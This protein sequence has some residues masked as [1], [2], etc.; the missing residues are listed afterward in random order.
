MASAAA[1]AAQRPVRSMVYPIGT[2]LDL[3]LID[4]SGQ[5]DYFLVHPFQS[6]M[7][8]LLLGSLATA[9]APTGFK[10]Q[11]I[12]NDGFEVS[13]L[14]EPQTITSFTVKPVSLKLPS[15]LGGAP[16]FLRVFAPTTAQI[17]YVTAHM[18]SSEVT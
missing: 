10:I 1:P 4:A 9:T 5:R 13:E 14:T 12:G 18:M 2:E 3:S 11:L 8:D 7:Q 6:S 16:L 17:V 15:T